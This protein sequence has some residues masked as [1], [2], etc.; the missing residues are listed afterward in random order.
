VIFSA[1]IF[2]DFFEIGWKKQL[3]FQ[4]LAILIAFNFGAFP[5]YIANPFNGEIIFFNQQLFFFLGIFLIGTW[6]LVLVNAINWIDGVDGVGGGVCFIGALS[7]FLLSLKPEVNQPPIGILAISL[8]GAIL[9]FLFL[10]FYPA[11]IFAGTSGSM[12]MGYLLAMLSIFAGAKIATTLL[13]MAIPIIDALWVVFERLQSGQSIFEADRRH[14]HHK[15]LKLG[16]SQRN[17]SLL[18]YFFTILISIFALKFS[19]TGKVIIFIFALLSLSV[20]V[21]YVKNKL[22]KN[23]I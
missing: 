13:V 1:S 2:D 11:R 8:A 17:I 4:I 15:L 21:F 6:V 23:S 10:N 12:T 7:L 9:G 18:Y 14:L 5:Q 22:I 20:V 19:G 3:F 16:I